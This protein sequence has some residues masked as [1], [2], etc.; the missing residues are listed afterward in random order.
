VRES[1]IRIA[2]IFNEFGVKRMIWQMWHQCESIQQV[3]QIKRGN[4][5]TFNFFCVW[6]FDSWCLVFQFVW[7]YCL[8]LYLQWLKTFINPILGRM[9][10]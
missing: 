5:Q 3:Q 8:N 10:V 6:E 4:L 7:F 2:C 1:S 9:W